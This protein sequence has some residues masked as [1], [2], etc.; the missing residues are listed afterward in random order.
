MIFCRYENAYTADLD[1][2][3]KRKNHKVKKILSDFYETEKPLMIVNLKYAGYSNSRSAHSSFLQAIRAL[4]APMITKVTKH[5]LYVIRIDPDEY[6]S[7][8]RGK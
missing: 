2:N 7:C 1:S 6:N 3:R 4:K 8:R 5:Y